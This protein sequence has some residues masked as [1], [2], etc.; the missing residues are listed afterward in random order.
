M[1]MNRAQWN[2][3]A[4]RF[5]TEVCDITREAAD[6]LITRY[7]DSV[8]LPKSGAVLVDLGCGLG[9][10]VNKFGHRFSRAIA[11]DHADKIIDRAKK[12][13]RCPSP[14]EWLV[15]DFASVPDIVGACADLAVCMNVITSSDAKTRD[16]QW[17]ALAR[18][19]KPRGHALVVLPSFESD[20]IVREMG[21]RAGRAAE[22]KATDD[23]LVQ[24]DTATQKAYTH[25][26]LAAA[27]T[28]NGF[29][30]KRL[31]RAHYPWSIEGLRKPASAKTLPWDWI[32]LA[33]KKK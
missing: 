24:R 11:T 27:L 20:K 25:D 29:G 16:A 7:V 32:C 1:G 5:E 13:S 4:D 31:G 28:T 12:Q 18:V 19:T 26:E 8:P 22:F 10:F 15:S 21:F 6:G 30:V 9:S 3:L 23:G 14:V 2:K 33:Q 17:S